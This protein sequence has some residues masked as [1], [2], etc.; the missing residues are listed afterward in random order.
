MFL[1]VKNLCMLDK[2]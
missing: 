2:L 1:Q